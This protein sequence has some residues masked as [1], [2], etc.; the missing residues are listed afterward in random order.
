MSTAQQV[1]SKIGQLTP[2]QQDQVL[3]LVEAL[4]QQRPVNTTAPR[5][6]G[7]LAE[8]RVDISAEEI[9]AARSEMWGRF[10]REASAG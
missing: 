8:L 7:A 9:D 5:L 6:I 2:E 3:R 1:I 4:A 10:P